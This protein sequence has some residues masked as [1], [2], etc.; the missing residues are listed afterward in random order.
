MVPLCVSAV[1]IPNPLSDDMNTFED[2]LNAV[3]GF[4]FWVGLTVAPVM[5]IVAG[6]I[7]VT[8]GG[9]PERVNTAKRWMLWTIVGLIIVLVAR[10]LVTVL[11]SVLEVPD[12]EETLLIPYFFGAITYFLNKTVKGRDNLKI[13]SQK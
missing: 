7:Y 2:L 5:L 9:S 1:V 12:E 4:I 13:N 11:Q 3:V 8:S 10:G 6:F